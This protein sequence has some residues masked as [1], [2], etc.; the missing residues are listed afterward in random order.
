MLRKVTVAEMNYDTH[1]SLCLF[2][3]GSLIIKG[4]SSFYSLFHPLLLVCLWFRCAAQWFS[5]TSSY[6]SNGLDYLDSG[7]QLYSFCEN[8]TDYRHFYFCCRQSHSVIPSVVKIKCGAFS[9]LILT[10]CSILL[11]KSFKLAPCLLFI[12]GNFCKIHGKDII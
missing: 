11:L 9:S 10:S 5:K 12:T 1:W 2:L 8:H 4:V 7:S 3:I 6:E